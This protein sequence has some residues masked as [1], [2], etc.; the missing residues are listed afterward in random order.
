M[1][2]KALASVYDLDGAFFGAGSIRLDPAA[3]GGESATENVRLATVGVGLRGSPRHAG[4][5][6]L[7]VTA[8]AVDRSL[9]G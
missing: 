5:T 3:V 1:S 2:E 7:G 8:T 4:A 6:L 9:D